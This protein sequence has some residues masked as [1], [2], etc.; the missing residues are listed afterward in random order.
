MNGGRQSGAK[1][2]LSLTVAR[3]LN[4]VLTNSGRLA[5]SARDVVDVEIAGGV[6]QL[7]HVEAI[8]ALVRLAGR[9]RVV[10][11]P[12]LVEGAHQQ[13][14]GAGP[15]AHAALEGAIEDR[16]PAVRLEA[17]QEQLA[18]LVGGEG[19]AYPL[20]SQPSGELSRGGQLE[21]SGPVCSRAHGAMLAMPDL[22]ALARC[23]MN[24]IRAGVGTTPC[25][26]RSAAIAVQPSRRRRAPG[27]IQF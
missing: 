8:V 26:R 10:E 11:A 18:G 25:S 12:E 5:P 23:P 3:Q 7:G 14:L 22:I 6:R 19:E 27:F 15:E 17:E 24:E 4:R 1:L 13:P 20:L 9:Q 21:G 16:Q 2:W